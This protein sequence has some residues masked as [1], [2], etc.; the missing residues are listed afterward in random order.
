[1]P[2]FNLM[3]VAPGRRGR[4]ST[5]CGAAVVAALALATAGAALADPELDALKQQVQDLQ[6]QYDAMAKQQAARQAVAP[7]AVVAAS[8]ARAPT[9]APGD[10]AVGMNG[11]TLYGTLDVNLAY[12]SNG[13]PQSDY[14][15]GGTYSL[16]QKNANRTIFGA[17]ENGLTQSRIGLQ[18]SKE[19]VGGWTGIFRLETIFNPLSGD[20]ADALKSMTVDN[21]KAVAAQTTSADSSLAGQLFN[22]AAYLG[23]SH[24]EFGTITVGRQNGLLADGIAKYDPMATAQAFSPHGRSGNYSAGGST[25]SGRL[26]NSIKYNAQFGPLHTGVQYQFNGA[27]GSAGNAWQLVLGGLSEHGSVDVYYVKKEQAIASS[28]LTAAQVTT[29][30][31]PFSVAPGAA[32]PCT[33]AGGGGTALDRALAGTVSDNTDFTVMGTYDF[34]SVKLFAGYEHIQFAN[35]D[36]PLPAGSATIG[37]YVLAYVNKQNGAGSTFEI[38][39]IW[40]YEFVGLRYAFTPALEG[41]VAW[42]RQEQSAYATGANAGCNSAIAANCSGLMSAYS[43]ALVY[44]ISKRFDAYGGAM[45]SGVKGGLANGFLHTNNIDPTLGVRYTF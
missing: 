6:R 25:E 14:L 11:V 12:L 45:W 36:T 33:V 17:G 40:Q 44:S 10:G 22:S 5:A 9:Q 38:H 28:S 13:M 15:S 16:I 24:Q 35:P 8:P 3:T 26:D 37:G 43:G 20:I 4:R 29:L 31:C 42:Y 32:A 18:G 39:R 1:M 34:G 2:N 7:V 21:G 19:I 41:R 23:F 30:N 27:S